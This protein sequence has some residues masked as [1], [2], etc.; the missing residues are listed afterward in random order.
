M[1]EVELIN[2]HGR[3]RQRRNRLSVVGVAVAVAAGIALG[4]TVSGGSD[5]QNPVA[6]LPENPSAA[7]IQSNQTPVRIGERAI[8]TPLEPETEVVAT[9]VTTTSIDVRLDRGAAHF[10]VGPN[11]R[12]PFRVLAGDVEIEVVGTEFTVARRQ[13]QTIVQVSH[14]VVL[15]R[16]NGTEYT[17]R[18]GDRAQFPSQVEPTKTADTIPPAAMPVPAAMT[19]P[20][21]SPLSPARRI[22][23]RDQESRGS[24]D[25]ATQTGAETGATPPAESTPEPLSP[26]PVSPPTPV[27]PPTVD[28]YLVAADNARLAGRSSEAA[29]LLRRALALELDPPREAI[30]A[31][32]LGRVLIDELDDPVAAASEFA[33][34]RKVAPNGLL[35]EDALA[36]EVEAWAKAGRPQRARTRAE[37]YISRYPSGRRTRAVRQLGGLE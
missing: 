21:R 13:Q 36:R 35:A 24:P 32:T 31:F 33:R 17:L 10:E 18:A 12:A 1:V 37:L 30:A 5:S 14:G 22:E 9:R 6:A 34:V 28:E 23:K 11:K 25:I 3:I 20:T 2:L 29:S 27:A 19:A 26:P 7:G 16:S 15:V 8:V 4:V